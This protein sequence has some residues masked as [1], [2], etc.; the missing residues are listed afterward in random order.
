MKDKSE[1]V[2]HAL[3]LLMSIMP[4]KTS[5]EFVEGNVLYNDRRLNNHICGVDNIMKH[6]LTFK[7]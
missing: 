2:T 5:I 1:E 7:E 3:N 6:L 4:K